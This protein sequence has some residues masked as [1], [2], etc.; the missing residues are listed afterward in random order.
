MHVLCRLIILASS[1]YSHLSVKHTHIHIYRPSLD[2]FFDSACSQVGT[3]YCKDNVH[4][5]DEADVDVRNCQTHSLTHLY[6]PIFRSVFVCVCTCQT[7]L[8]RLCEQDKAVRTQEEKMQQL[9]REKV[10]QCLSVC[11]CHHMTEADR[12]FFVK[13]VF[14]LGMSEDIGRPILLARY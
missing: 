12:E 9:H 13:L 11:L 10:E 8:S 3:D 7:K 1:F 14:K 5:A 6:W 2:S 4:H